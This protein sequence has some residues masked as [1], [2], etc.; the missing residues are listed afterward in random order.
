MVGK[1]RPV[2]SRVPLPES[3]EGFSSPWDTFYRTQFMGSGTEALS[4]AISMAVGRAPRVSKPEVIIPA[5]G[6]PDLVA[7]IVAQGAKPVLVDLE[8]D[9]PCMSA[10]GVLQAVTSSTVAVVGVGFLG[11]PERLEL[12]SEICHENN[13]ILIEDSAQCFPPESSRK[14]LADFVVLSFGRGKP[15]NLMGGGAL[16]VRNETFTDCADTLGKYSVR[17]LKI[18]FLWFTKRAVFN[19]LMSRISYYFLERLPFLG[20]GATRFHQ[21]ES[22]SRLEMPVSLFQA[23]LREFWSRPHVQSHY[24]SKLEPLEA[25]DWIF[26]EKK[27]AGVPGNNGRQRL[28]RYPVLAPDIETRDRALTALNSAGIGA[29]VFYGAALPDIDGLEIFLEQRD[30][31]IAREFSS[32]LLTLPAHEDV[33]MSDIELVAEVLFDLIDT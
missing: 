33:E 31:P 14:P 22:I 7:A 29:S 9:L 16:L 3:R 2:G 30:C 23:G 13:L 11:I 6:C 4:A 21:L 1:L 15:I 19:A 8:P 26:L 32:R 28:L 27:A 10:S 24:Q 25:A 20:I 18:N 5:Y 17:Q 12:L